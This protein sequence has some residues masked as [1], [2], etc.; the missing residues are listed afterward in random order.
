MQLSMCVS[1]YYPLNITNCLPRR[2]WYSLYTYT[3]ILYIIYIHVY[4]LFTKGIII[5]YIVLC[6]HRI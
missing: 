2:V 4:V 5:M 1:K 3:E 6:A